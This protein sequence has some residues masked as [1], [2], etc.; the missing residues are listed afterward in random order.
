MSV[1]AGT[2]FGRFEVL[3]PLGAGA[4]GEVYR[5]RDESLGREVAIKVLPARFSA[6]PERLRR[7]DTEARAAGTL[8]HPNVVTTYDLGTHDGMPYVVSELLEGETLRALLEGGKLPLRKAID[9]GRQTALGLAAA[10]ARGIVHRDLKPENL[11]VTLDGHVKILDFGLAKLIRPEQGDSPAGDSLAATMTQAGMIM[12]TAGYMAPEQVRA[13]AADHRSDI[14]SLGCVLYEMATGERAFHRDT[15]VETLNAILREDP[16]AFPADV[17]AAAPGL[18]P[19]VLRCLEKRPGER[20]ESA[21]DL[22]FSL[23]FSAWSPRD[24]GAA[25]APPQA[26]IAS[27]ELS[28]HRLTFQRGSILR[29]R[30]TPDGHSVVY[31]GAWEGRPVEVFWMHIGSPEARSIGA[32]GSDVLAVSPGG[33]LAVCLK[34]RARSG[35]IS[36][37]TLARMPLGGVVARPL[38]EAVDEADWGPDGQIAVARE[39][40]GMGR[41]EYPIGR[42]L[43]ETAGWASHVRVSRDGARVAF[44]HHELP[45]NDAGSVTVVELDG[46]SRALSEG[47]GTIRGLAWSADGREVWFTAHREGAGRNLHGVSLEGTLRTLIAVP[48]QLCIQDV[49]PNGRV[50]LTHAM[51][52]QAIMA[53]APG[54]SSARDMSWLDWSLL[55]DLSA[56]GTMMLIHESGEGGGPE[57]AICLRPTDG[58]PAVRLGDGYPLQFSPDGMSVLCLQHGADPAAGRQ[59]AL[60]PTGV[61]SPSVIPTPGLTC[62]SAQ[63]MPDGT[64]VLIAAME[65]GRPLRLYRQGLDGGERVPVGPEGPLVMPFFVSPDSRWVALRTGSRPWALYPLAGGEPRAIPALEPQDEVLPWTLEAGSILVHQEARIPARI[66]RIDLESGART[67]WREIA[68][69]DPTG[70]ASMRGFRF[71][72]DG[73]GCGYTFTMQLDDLYLLEGLR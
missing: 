31:G 22:A 6:D 40:G 66:D 9:Y 12:G 16:A 24:P 65:P 29:A 11:F 50:L 47:W 23:A 42:V 26:A 5:A 2:R 34:R 58:S 63:W 59:L 54:E 32:V 64:S 20:F 25:E 21:R 68:P 48:G 17:R 45:G 67:L 70:M 3:G 8:H 72:P 19:I 60:L 71:T 49:H 51:E 18:V 1:P 53:Q 46:R 14:F 28:F 7:F 61:G 4:M 36:S 15:P 37:G 52:R 38:L 57:T 39:V 13:E 56:D 35:F 27:P 30:F 10:H 44:I 33:E 69:P 73:K 62:R 43:F 41:V 55:R